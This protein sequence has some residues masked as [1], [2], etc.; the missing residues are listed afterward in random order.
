MPVG[1]AAA[2]RLTLERWSIVIVVIVVVVVDGTGMI[3][4]IENCSQPGHIPDQTWRNVGWYLE[5]Y[6]NMAPF[7]N[8][9]DLIPFFPMDIGV[10][11][12]V[13]RCQTDLKR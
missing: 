6:G 12:P 2:T 10:Q 9:M 13:F 1:L 3:W 5:T 4:R 7:K 11:L 8:P